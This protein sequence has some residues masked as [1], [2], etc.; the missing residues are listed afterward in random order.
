MAAPLGFPGRAGLGE[1]PRSFPRVILGSRAVW[2]PP[3][4]LPQSSAQKGKLVNGYTAS[5]YG[6]QAYPGKDEGSERWDENPIARQPIQDGQS[7]DGN[8]AEERRGRPQR[9]AIEP[10]GM[11]CPIR[12]TKRLVPGEAT[13]FI[14]EPRY[15]CATN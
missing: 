3:W 13:G 6:S 9:S 8:S 7:T 11:G 2:D 5:C 12:R 15:L 10:V 14:C 1:I 4:L